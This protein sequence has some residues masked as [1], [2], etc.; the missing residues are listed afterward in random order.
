MSNP[1]AVKIWSSPLLKELLLFAVTTLTL[2][3]VVQLQALDALTEDGLTLD[4][5]KVWAVSAAY[6]AIQT[7][8]KQG[9]AW[10][11]AHLAGSQL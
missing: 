6:A 9:I 1:V 7:A 11:V 10:A 3:A 8:V 5:A 4:E 2:V